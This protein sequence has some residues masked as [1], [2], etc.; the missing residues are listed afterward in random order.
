MY[1]Y[2]ILVNNACIYQ[3]SKVYEHDEDAL[4][5]GN[6]MAKFLFDNRDNDEVCNAPLYGDETLDDFVVVTWL[7]D[8]VVVD[9][10]TD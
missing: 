6:K 3:S 9:K 10:L 2:K 1:K 5:A 8:T 4:K 7:L